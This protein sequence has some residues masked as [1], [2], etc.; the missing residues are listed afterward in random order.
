MAILVYSDYSPS[1]PDTKRR[2]DL[3]Y[4]SWVASGIK[5][6]PFKSEEN[7]S[8][9]G[10]PHAVFFVRDMIEAGFAAGAY[11]IVLIANNDIQLEPGAVE[12][13]EKHITDTGCYWAY[14]KDQ[15][16]NV[17]GGVDL[18]GVSMWWWVLNGPMYLDFCHSCRGWDAA[19]KDLME[20]SGSLEGPR[21]YVHPRHDN[22]HRRR[23]HTPA[24]RYNE[25]LWDKWQS[26]KQKITQP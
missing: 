23:L 10:D 7:S 26:H 11:N 20:L 1:D 19:M 17:D 9:I 5:L 25:A 16:G 12:K 15:Q 3:A 21:V 24:A 13:I 6:L 14:R 22:D 2:N 4:Q 8:K 18:I